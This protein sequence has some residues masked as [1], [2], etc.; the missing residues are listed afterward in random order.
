MSMS[1]GRL[2]QDGRSDAAYGVAEEPFD[3]LWAGRRLAGSSTCTSI[4]LAALTCY[5]RDK[6][7]FVQRRSAIV[8]RGPFA[9]LQ[10]PHSQAARDLRVAPRI[11]E[12]QG[13]AHSR[14]EEECD[15]AP[16]PRRSGHSECPPDVIHD[17]KNAQRW[18]QSRI[19][20]ALPPC[21]VML[22]NGSDWRRGRRS[23]PLDWP[24]C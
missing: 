9:P 8:R 14:Q 15:T 24:G 17:C 12:Q 19:G 4:S 5:R 10:W 16:S 22:S 3:K 11:D 18:F 6:M 13:Y 1:P 7:T 2:Q 23:S 20:R 21:R